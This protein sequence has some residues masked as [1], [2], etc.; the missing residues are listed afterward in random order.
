MAI[1]AYLISHSNLEIET[2]KR[3]S[4]KETDVLRSENARRRQKLEGSETILYRPTPNT[5]IQLAPMYQLSQ[6]LK[7]LVVSRMLNPDH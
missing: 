3:K 7:R 6:K 4:A 1:S 5:K 2:V